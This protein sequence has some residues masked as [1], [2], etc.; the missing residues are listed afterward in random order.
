MELK[1]DVL[2]I[3][4]PMVQLNT[5]YPS[6]AYLQ[7]F[8][9]QLKIDR[10]DFSLG[11]VQWW[12]GGH[13]LYRQVFSENGLQFIFSRSQAAARN[14]IAAAEKSGNKDESYNLQ[15]F[16]IRRR[17]WIRWIPAITEIL[18]GTAREMC[19]EFVRSPSVPRGQRMEVFL[20]E[21]NREPDA[22]DARILASLALADIADYITAVF[23]PDFSLV[24]YA[25]SLASSTRG[26]DA[27]EDAVKAPVLTG[28]YQPVLQAAAHRISSDRRTLVCISCPFPGT[29]A[30]ALYTGRF[31]K[32]QYGSRVFVVLGGG[33]V[34]TE[35][36][37]VRENRL[38]SYIDALS[39]DRGYGSYIDLFEHICRL[40]ESGA[41]FPAERLPSALYRMR[42]FPVPEGPVPLPEAVAPGQPLL[43][44]RT[45]GGCSGAAGIHSA[46][47]SVPDAACSD[48][49]GSR[50]GMEPPECPAYRSCVELEEWYT[51]TLVP[52]YSGIDFSRYPRL[53]DSR[54]PMH[55]LWSD[56]AWLKAYL[57]HGCYWHR[58]AFCDTT[59]DYVCSYRMTDIHRLYQGLY[60]QAQMTGVRGVHLVDEAAPPV[61][62]RQ[63]A[64]ENLTHSRPLSFWGNIRYEKVFSRD[65]ADLLA[66][67]GM[68]GVSGGIEIATG[69]GMDAVCKGTDIDSV[70]A[71]CAAFKEAGILTHA[72]MIYGYWIETPQI[73]IDSV[74]T[75]RQM[76]AAGL[77][78]S[79]FWHKFTLTRHSRIFA[80]YS[81]GLHPDLQP[82]DSDGRIIPAGSAVDDDS[83]FAANDVRFSGEEKSNRYT[84][85]LEISLAAWM[86][87]RDL[88][89]N[90][91]S[92]FP[93]PM[94][95]PSV[96]PDY[97]ERSLARYEQNRNRSFDDYGHFIRCGGTDYIWLG[98]APELQRHK[99]RLQFTWSYMGE[100]LYKDFPAGYS[101][102]AARRCCTLLEQLVPEYRM[103]ADKDPAPPAEPAPGDT[104]FSAGANVN[105]VISSAAEKPDVLPEF[106]YR[107]I[108]GNGLCRIT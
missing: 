13:E 101:D 83:V 96:P 82:L 44:S 75:L 50:S 55:R 85:P 87:G 80:E 10:P 67:G 22:D 93:F 69:T 79:A 72:Y 8:F 28:L 97:I 26:F 81:R 19:H 78:D 71:A 25:E 73:L 88:Y 94:P 5:P 53:A 105:R 33:Y 39:F 18:S 4:P 27:V 12:D 103:E 11:T 45:S 99:G 104:G 68:T 6:G 84:Q 107:V 57:A 36:R 37:Q 89:K 54:N 2:I 64:L 46:E 106:L 63:F 23:D 35:L 60:R 32:E 51:R 77:I 29:L 95:K 42:I 40:P 30:G 70:I 48:A 102:A 58:C 38:C 31:F 91:R 21:L 9:K 24:R 74:E 43:P 62:L 20:S 61:A 86:E 41:S 47:K 49:T 52:D 92:W 7:A 16:L 34:N 14:R 100:L 98:G 1:T 76:F 56:G 15:R 90:V 65:T 59:L 66:H 3:Q 17:D 108:R